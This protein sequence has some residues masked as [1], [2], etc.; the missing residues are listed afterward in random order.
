MSAVTISRVAADSVNG[1]V[2]RGMLQRQAKTLRGKVYGMD[3]SIARDAATASGIAMLVGQLEKL[4]PQINGPLTSVTWDRDIPMISGG[5]FVNLVSAVYANYGTTGTDE[6]GFIY[7]GSSDIATS[8]VDLSKETWQTITFANSLSVNLLDQ[9]AVQKIGRSLQQ[10]LEDGIQLNW[11]KLMDKNGYRGFA[12]IG[13]YGLVNNPDVVATTAA[14]NG[15]TSA[16][17][18]WADK[19]ADQIVKDINDG[20]TAQW[21]AVGYD[22]SMM[23]N[24]VGVPPAQFS[25]LVSKKVSEAGNISVLEYIKQNNLANAQDIDLKIV[26]MRQL[27]GSGGSSADRMVIYRNDRRALNFEMTMP[28]GRMATGIIPNELRFVST[29]VGQF[30]QVKFI[31]PMACRYVDGI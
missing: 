28:L 14:S 30:S 13:T 2:K 11:Q 18:K 21:E 22:T 4:D 31:Y 25:M 19:T 5:G 27:V 7:N 29:F 8:Q 9:E 3:A 1:I 12:K 23:A 17:T 15:A 26:P 16:S 20:L 10:L 24:Q 6:E